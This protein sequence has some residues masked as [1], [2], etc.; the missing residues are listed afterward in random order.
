MAKNYEVPE[1]SEKEF[2]NFT[3]EGTVLI[4]FFAEWCMPC[5]MLT[6]IIEE[7]SE[8]FKDKLKVGKVNIE[9]NS[10][11]AAK[12]NVSSIPNLILFKNGKIV[13]QIIGVMPQEE[14]ENVIRGYI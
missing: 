13:E 4:D 14:I 10:E 5:V 3:K 7:I 9:D 12:F 11:L 8:N 2:E 6:P 1:L